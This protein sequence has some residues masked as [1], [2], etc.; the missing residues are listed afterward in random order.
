[1]THRAPVLW[2]LGF[3]ASQI[4]KARSGAPGWQ[5]EGVLFSNSDI[6]GYVKHT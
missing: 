3:I 2:P 5:E 1:M 6:E 4:S